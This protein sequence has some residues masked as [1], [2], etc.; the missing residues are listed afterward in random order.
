V[1][2]PGTIAGFRPFGL[3]AALVFASLFPALS[4]LPAP[5][6]ADEPP[7]IAGAFVFPVGDEL[8]F[9]KPAPGEPNGFHVTDPYLKVRKGRKHGRQRV[10]YGVDLSGSAGGLTVRA[11][12]A[13]VV[14]VSDANALIKVRSPQRVKLPTVV[15]GKRIYAWGVRY[16]SAWK[17]RTGW[18]NRVVIRHTL[19]DGQ[20]VYSLYAHLMS[21]SVLVHVGDH[22]SAGQPIA[23]VGR[24]GHATAPHLHLEIR[25]T[26]I[27]ESTEISD[28]DDSESSDEG[29]VA[30]RPETELPHTVD[31]LVFL[32]DH[33]L[34]F[35]D[36]EPGS[37]Q[38]RYALAAVKDGLMSCDRGR[39]DP[40]E[41][42]TRADFY[43]ALVTSFHLATPFT[44]NRFE[45]QLD[46]LID[47]G[48][49]D[50]SARHQDAR[51][52]IDRADALELVL[53]CLDRGAARALSMSR[54]TGDQ[55]AR[56][57][58]ME[59]AGRDAANEAE[60]ESRR[61]AAAETMELRRD[62]AARDERR[63]KAARERGAPPP[64]KRSKVEAVKPVPMLDPG[65]DSLAQSKEKLS[66][67]EVCLLIASAL[68]IGS[69]NLSALE[70]AA[71]RAA[72]T[73]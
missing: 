2:A 49:L 17:W 35:E 21:R 70:R 66:R 10:H 53:R 47:T 59:F 69:A 38:T 37:W 8:D 6:A 27:D 36:L 41:D 61:L 15:D 64:R 30:E 13:G 45:S 72:K 33:V 11:I 46:A 4:L 12:A 67:A 50:S 19:P 23:K 31:P 24:T 48:I 68:R 73:G 55:L 9:K 34:K 57:F 40:N 7:P 44:K 32:V 25:T 39:F 26:R 18:G 28:P 52:P 63:A 22:V 14:D 51:D 29:E 60:Q 65:F 56:D 1:R 71:T 62:A 5:V 3:N 16:R 20:V 43:A 54:I 58:N 42:V